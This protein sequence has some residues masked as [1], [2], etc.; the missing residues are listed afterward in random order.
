MALRRAFTL[1]EVLVVVAIIALLIAT[2]LPSLAAARVSARRTMSASNLRQ[3]GIGLQMYTQDHKGRM[4]QTTHGSPMWRSWI[5]SLAGGL[6]PATGKRSR[7]Y[8]GGVEEVRILS[9]IHI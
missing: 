1:I 2:L 5:F 7:T 9:L 3:I 4:P 6:N 8:L